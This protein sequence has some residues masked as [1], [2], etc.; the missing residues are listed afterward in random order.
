MEE[1][2]GSE[3]GWDISEKISRESRIA[4]RRVAFR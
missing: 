2:P 1:K 3:R 4:R